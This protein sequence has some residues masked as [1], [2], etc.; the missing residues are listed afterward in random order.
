MR[1]SSSISAT[2][3]PV[4]GARVVEAAQGP[5]ALQ[6]IPAIS[7]ARDHDQVQLATA[8]RSLVL[9]QRHPIA[10]EIVGTDQQR[11]LVIRAHTTEDLSHVKTQLHARFP[12]ATFVPLM[13]SD[14][15]FHLA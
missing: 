10:L 4:R 14:D 5:L 2:T 9:D 3:Q 8:M 7:H 12:H 1:T 13:G 11:S 15:P 6:M